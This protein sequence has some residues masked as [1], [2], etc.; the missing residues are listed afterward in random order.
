MK[1]MEIIQHPQIDGLH[2]FFDTVDYRTPHIH[3]EIELIWILQG[4]LEV[5]S[6]SMRYLACCGEMVL[7]H[8]NQTHEFHKL[9]ESCT[10]LCIQVAPKLI[11][12]IFPAIEHIRLRGFCPA[13]FLSPQAYR[14]TQYQILQIMRQYLQRTPCYELFCVGQICLLLHRLFTAIPHQMLTVEEN[15]ERER[16]NARLMRLLKFVDQN[17]MHKIRLSDFAQTENLS[18]SYLSHFVKDTLNQSFQDYVATVRFNA[19]CKMIA[20]GERKMLDICM[21]CGFSDY[22]YFSRAFQQRVGVTPEVYSKQQEN[23]I[24]EETKIHH[25]LHSLE[26]F[27]SREKSLELLNR[28]EKEYRIIL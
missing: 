25:S 26:R 21:E 4:S 6:G 12:G 23:L 18:M 11:K 19:A 16:R 22:R 7:F 13:A 15:A 28:F 9:Q 14:E 2:I 1:E 3:G 5:Q 27:Y 10:F 8:S 17:Y 24:V 20:G